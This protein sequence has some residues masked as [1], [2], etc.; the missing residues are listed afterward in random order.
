MLII[1]MDGLCLKIDKDV[2]I[3]DVL[4]APDDSDVGYI[5]EVDIE[6]PKEIHNKLK[7]YP[8]AP[9]I[10][11]PQDDWMSDY[12]QELKNKMILL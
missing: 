12:Q 10:L 2:K 8:P 11:T 3:D 5:V 6:C 7:E 9:E 1:F 4:E